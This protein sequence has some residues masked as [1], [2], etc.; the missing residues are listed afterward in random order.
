M[1]NGQLVFLYCL[2][3]AEGIYFIKQILTHMPSSHSR[4]SRERSHAWE[5][6]PL[7][8]S[9]FLFCN[10]FAR[11]RLLLLLFLAKFIS[12]LLKLGS[13]HSGL[14]LG[15][16]IQVTIGNHPVVVARLANAISVEMILIIIFILLSF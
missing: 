5:S 16:G 6:T 8:G 12:C 1:I 14:L 2:L 10:E 15:C 11:L 9:L 7:F 3:F 4:V 13:G